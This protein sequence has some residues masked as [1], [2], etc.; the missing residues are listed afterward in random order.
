MTN[1]SKLDYWVMRIYALCTQ[2]F[3]NIHQNNKHRIIYYY[4]WVRKEE[5]ER[6]V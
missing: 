6:W 4:N 3:T 5:L 2:K 1:I